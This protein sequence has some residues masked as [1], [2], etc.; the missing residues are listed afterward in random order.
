MMRKIYT[1]IDIGSDSIKIVVTELIKNKFHILASSSKKSRGLKRGLVV[2]HD[3]AVESLKEALDEI[4]KT[5]GTKIKKALVTVPT[6]DSRFTI[7]EEE[8]DLEEEISGDD[9][10]SLLN[11][12]S[13]NKIK[14]GEEM[15]SLFPIAYMLDQK[16]FTENPI[17]KKAKHFGVKALLAVAPKKQIYDIFQIFYELDVEVIDITFGCIGDYYEAKTADTDN[18]VGAIINIG[19]EKMDV[20]VFNKGILI[21]TGIINLGSKNVDKDISYIYG[22]N[23]ENARELKEKFSS[24]SRRYADINESLEINISEEEKFS[25][26]QYEISKNVEARVAEL[27]KI[28]KKEINNLTNRKIS[29]IIVTG[30]ITEL[31]GVSY[32]VENVLGINA[33]TLNSTTIGARSNKFSS[34]MGMIKYYHAKKQ[35]QMKDVSFIEKEDISSILDNKR[36]MLDLEDD[37]I[38]SKIFG[39]FANN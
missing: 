7:V 33:T 15:V 39:Y 25:V 4:E 31:L 9:V 21:K 35:S 13:L 17:G 23:N 1:G 18:K 38:I 20:S 8:I 14:E 11:S 19:Y 32:V 22:I 10:V 24:S 37:T 2:D 6:N 29:Y 3:I 27:L 30:G 26:N 16:K 28:A 5:L 12:A 36:S 34:V